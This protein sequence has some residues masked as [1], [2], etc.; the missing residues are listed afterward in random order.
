MKQKTANWLIDKS[1]EPILNKFEE[2]QRMI[3]PTETNYATHGIHDYPGKFIPHFPNIF[4]Q[5]LTEENNLVLDPMAGCGTTL[6]E[7]SLMNRRG[8]GIEIDPIGY[9]ISK[10]SITPQKDENLFEG[11]VNLIRRVENLLKSNEQFKIKIPDESEYPNALL[12]FREDVLQELI[13]IR[14]CIF[15]VEDS[16]FRNFA[17]LCLSSI[18]R[19]V[20]NADPR[21]I[22]PERNKE[23]LERPR[24]NVLHEFKAAVQTIRKR[25]LSFSRSV[26]YHQKSVAFLGDARNIFLK[27][28]SADLIFTSPPYAYAMD[29]ARVHQLSTLLF[30]INNEELKRRRRQ[31]IGTD[32]ISTKKD[33][34]SFDELEFT[35]PEVLSAY[36]KDRKWGLV[37]FNYLKDMLQ[38]SKECYRVLKPEKHL[39]YIIGKSTIK[40]T[41]FST[42]EVLTQIC[43]NIG[44]KLK[45]R[46]ERPYYSYRLQTKRNVQSNNIKS[47]IFLVFQK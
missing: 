7:S 43:E 42:D 17:L 40:K 27:D 38:V 18:V 19:L 32:R 24:Q 15:E 23:M 36:L 47:D 33:L 34:G 10:V 16:N 22:F 44:F 13:L 28:N 11:S 46:L 37:L 8:I 3:P 25:I 20:S 9:L 41:S 21:D 12:W 45:E 5:E 4:I 35:K 1:R 30:I 29:Y 26:Q 39:V 2:I 14:D 6:I 31:Y